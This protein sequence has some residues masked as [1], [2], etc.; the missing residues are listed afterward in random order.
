[1]YDH[2]KQ[3]G[4]IEDVSGQW[5]LR[6]RYDWESWDQNPKIWV[7]RGRLEPNAPPLLK[8]RKR[9]RRGCAIRLWSKLLSTGW[10]RVTPQWD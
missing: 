4:W 2:M 1:M 8:N 9:I 6:F 7:E 5:I 3:D 10:R